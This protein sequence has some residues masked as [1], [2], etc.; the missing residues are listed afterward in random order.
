MRGSLSRI[1]G[2]SPN[3]SIKTD[4]DLR[5]MGCGSAGV[6]PL[7]IELSPVMPARAGGGE[8]FIVG[9]GD[10]QRLK[11][12]LQIAGMRSHQSFCRRRRAHRAQHAGQAPTCRCDACPAPGSLAG[13][14][15]P[16]PRQCRSRVVARHSQFRQ[17][18]SRPRRSRHRLPERRGIPSLLSRGRRADGKPWRGR[19]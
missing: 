1:I 5:S 19:R 6:R 9:F 17:A 11:E 14:A 4:L 7:W 18:L 10:R 15:A 13:A 12:A 16:K 2:A 3:S 8:K